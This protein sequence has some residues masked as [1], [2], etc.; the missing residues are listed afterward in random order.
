MLVVGE[1]IDGAVKVRQG[2]RKSRVP[3]G[4]E[5]HGAAVG[6]KAGAAAVGA[7]LLADAPVQESVGQIRPKHHQGGRV[8]VGFTHR[9]IGLGTEINLGV[10]APHLSNP[11]LAP[12]AG[13]CAVGTV[14][15]W[16]VVPYLCEGSSQL[17]F[18]IR[19]AHKQH[20]PGRRLQLIADARQLCGELR[21]LA[22][23]AHGG[24][25]G[26]QPAQPLE[27]VPAMIEQGAG[28]D[29]G[30]GG[31]HGKGVTRLGDRGF[32]LNMELRDELAQAHQFVESGAAEGALEQ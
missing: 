16:R 18:P 14:A 28:C 15:R 21:H 26:F 3:V 1:P 8:R 20:L 31:R 2:F 7:A 30:A 9:R 6:A 22:V 32:R 29:A 4:V 13:E 23:V 11:A 17:F 24:I 5:P 19:L 25:Q 10:D 27:P 12:I